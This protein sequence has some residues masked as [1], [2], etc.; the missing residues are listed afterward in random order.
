[1]QPTQKNQDPTQ[2]QLILN[3]QLYEEKLPVTSSAQ[4][5]A[6]FLQFAKSIQSID[7]WYVIF[8]D[9]KKRFLC[10]YNLDNFMDIPV[11]T[12]D[13]ACA[14]KMVGARHVMMARLDNGKNPNIGY[15]DICWIAELT[16]C[17]EDR[18][19]ALEDYLV[20]TEKEWR[21]YKGD[22]WLE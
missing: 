1:M 13:I 9:K 10:W 11:I 4:A 15:L 22:I 21:S 16:K 3:Y 5:S 7:G 2:A 14:A 20:V 8:L 19:V 12:A 18:K 17:C 6:L